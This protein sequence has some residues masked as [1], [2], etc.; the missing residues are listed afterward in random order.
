MM[1]PLDFWIRLPLAVF[2][3]VGIWTLFLE[4]M[5]L[6]WLGDF[7]HKTLPVFIQKPLYDCPPC[8]SSIWGTTIW[9]ASGGDFI[10]WVPFCLA[11]CGLLKILAHNL[12]R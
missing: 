10:F 12:L 6:G 11:L 5:L 3:I 4:G 7:F 2:I 1:P 9:F 8:M